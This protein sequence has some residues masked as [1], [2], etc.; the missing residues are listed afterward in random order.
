LFGAAVSVV[1]LWKSGTETWDT[2]AFQ[3]AIFISMLAV[4]QQIHIQRLSPE[5]KGVSPS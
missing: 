5:S 1:L 4:A 2:K 3:E